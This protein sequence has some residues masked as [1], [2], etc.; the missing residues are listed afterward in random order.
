MT[1][2][3]DYQKYWEAMATKAHAL[4]RTYMR[5]VQPREVGKSDRYDDERVNCK[6][7]ELDRGFINQ[8]LYDDMGEVDAAAEYIMSVIKDG[9][10]CK[11]CLQNEGGPKSCVHSQIE[12][13]PHTKVKAHFDW[14]LSM[15]GDQVYEVD[16]EKG[17]L[18][19]MSEKSEPVAIDG[20]R[21]NT[22]RIT[23]EK[24][25][26]TLD[27]SKIDADLVTAMEDEY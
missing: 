26:V 7:W 18:L 22:W 9:P 15:A 2:K 23:C 13:C 24:C 17:L 6:G 10:M 27:M 4:S 3:S 21:T 19:S 1:E 14:D 8:N 25:H 12:E 5:T 16:W 11:Y 20:S